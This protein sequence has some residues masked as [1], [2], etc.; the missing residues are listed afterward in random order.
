MTLTGIWCN[1]LLIISTTKNA[2]NCIKFWIPVGN[3]SDVNFTVIVLI[4]YKNGPIN[5]WPPPT[6]LFALASSVFTAENSPEKLLW[7]QIRNR[8][9]NPI[10]WCG[11][12]PLKTP[13]RS[14]FAGAKIQEDQNFR[15]AVTKSGLT[16]LIS[17]LRMM[18]PN[19]RFS[20]SS[21]LGFL[22][23]CLAFILMSS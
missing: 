10:N 16:E 1:T 3:L 2:L 13:L 21:L 8:L 12:S 4:S 23:C 14:I 7:K 22:P 9:L 6:L 20:C 19:L 15:L 17:Q 5:I 18:P 11:S